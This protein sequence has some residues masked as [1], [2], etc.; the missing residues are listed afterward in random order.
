MST[1]KRSAKKGDLAAFSA[2]YDG[3]AT[4]EL[5]FEAVGNRDAE[6]RWEISRRLLDDGADASPVAY[7]QSMLSILLGAHR[8]LGAHDG[9]L[10]QRL[11]NAGASV[12]YRERRGQLVIHLAALTRADADEDRRQL[13]EAFFSSSK[14]DLSLPVNPNNPDATIRQWLDG[15]VEQVPDKREVLAEFLAAHPA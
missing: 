3:N 15:L 1:A 4:S 10:A 11:V 9:E 8:R 14:L 13:Y 12:N 7:G 2:E 6:A 5:L